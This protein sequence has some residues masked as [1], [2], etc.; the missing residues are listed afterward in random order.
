M[1]LAMGTVGLV[2]LIACLNVTNLLLLRPLT[3]T[4]SLPFAGRPVP[5]WPARS[6]DAHR[7]TRPG[8]GRRRRGHCVAR[9]LI[10]LMGSY[11][12]G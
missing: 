2:L 9:G 3:V 4:A 12:P 7:S 8:D 5:P 10:P 1:Q 11:A 6:S